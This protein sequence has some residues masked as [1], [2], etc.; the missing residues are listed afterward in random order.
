MNSRWTTL[1]EDYGMFLVLLI[2]CL[3][4]TLVTIKPSAVVGS[5]AAPPVVAELSGSLPDKAAVLVVAG[6]NQAELNFASAVTN[7]LIDAG[8]TIASIVTG[9]PAD[10]GRTL[11]E[12]KAAG[13][14]IDGV[15]ASFRVANDWTVLANNPSTKTL[16]TA[17]PQPRMRSTFLSVGNLLSV[18][19]QTAIIAI[20]A[21]GMTLVIITAGIDLSVG[22][23]IALAAVIMAMVIR[24]GGGEDASIFYVIL[25]GIA[26]ILA[27]GLVGWFNGAM[28]AFFEVPAFIVTLAMMLSIRGLAQQ[29][30]NGQSISDVPDSIAWLGRGKLFDVVPISVVLMIALFILAHF[31]MS[32]TVFGRHIYAV[33]GNQE[34][35][36]LSGVNVKRTLIAAYLICGLGAGLGGVINASI[37]QS[38]DPNYAQ[39]YELYIIAAV[40]VGGTSLMG[41]RGKIFGTLVGALI[42]A[43]IG[44]GMNL[45]GIPDFTQRILLGIVLL[46]AVLL[47][48]AKKGTWRKA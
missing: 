44:N 8:Y 9:S 38:G 42:L 3:I 28:V 29:L 6:D 33:G 20:V 11:R 7:Q 5:S 24:A 46:L 35:A 14:A 25:G 37:Y 41:G 34:A 39:M 13:I 22:S 26:G 47:D 2:L 30:T 21:I 15:A 18:M 45:K 36:R 48:R 19:D 40:V 43:I 1:L 32:R 12:L 10:L 16:P 4:L 23:L 31:I 27:C 17:S